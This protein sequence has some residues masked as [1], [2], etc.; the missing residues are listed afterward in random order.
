MA[1]S[2]WLCFFKR[3]A[4]NNDNILVVYTAVRVE[5]NA[6]EHAGEREGR[7]ATV[8]AAVVVV[9]VVVLMLFF[10]LLDPAYLVCDDVLA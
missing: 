9:D 2:V 3:V 5:A 8:V 1:L 4:Q 10:V 7:R 6:E